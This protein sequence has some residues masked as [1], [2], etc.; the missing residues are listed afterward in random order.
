MMYDK[1]IENQIQL[2][3]LLNTYSVKEISELFSSIDHNLFS[4][5][6]CSSDDFL[7]LNAEFKNIYAQSKIIAENI[8]IVLEHFNDNKSRDF[9]AQLEKL[10]ESLKGRIELFDYKLDIAIDSFEKISNHLRLVFFPFKNYSQNLMSFKYL[11]AN[12]N[13][14]LSYSSENEKNKAEEI[15]QV[16]SQIIDE[17]KILSEKIVKSLNHLRKIS[18]L[19]LGNLYRIKKQKETNIESLLKDIR[20]VL[21]TL[22]IKYKKNQVLIPEIIEGSEKSTKSVDDIIKKLQYQDIIKQK[23]DHIQQTHRDLLKELE[24]FENTEKDNK[25]LNDLAKCF[26]R[27]RDI[28]GLQAAQLIHANKEYQSALEII[29]NQFLNIGDNMKYISEKGDEILFDE[30]GLGLYDDVIHLFTTANQVL[31]DKF[32]QNK[33]INQDITVLEKHLIL[34]DSYFNKLNSLNN[35]LQKSFDNSIQSIENIQTED[36]GENKAISQVKNIYSDIKNNAEKIFKIFSELILIKNN[37]ES[38]KGNN[39]QNLLTD[40]YI[41]HFKEFVDNIK[42]SGDKIDDKLEENRTISNHVLDIIKK[43]IGE[44]KYYK[45]FEKVI[46]EIITE[47]NTINYKLKT[48]HDESD[49]SKEENLKKLKEYYTMDTEHLIHDQ[50]IQDNELDIAVDSDDDGDIEFF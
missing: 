37:F 30:N 13:L 49:F 14:S 31:N 12:L 38:F 23:M 18:K 39:N 36:I 15:N 35:N 9:Y 34:I 42:K 2:K 6:E 17:T 1:D 24:K 44:I 16:T 40:D 21:D 20:S 48:D 28:A 26:L 33:V 45:Y 43:S 11:V 8:N 5:H 27:I 19:S 32:N 46:E 7:K 25:H 10:Y 4:L 47:L 3:A 22:K 50:I 29:I 41:N